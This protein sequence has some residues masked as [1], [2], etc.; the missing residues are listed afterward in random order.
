MHLL[1]H[2]RPE[3]FHQKRIGSYLTRVDG[4]WIKHP[5]D[6]ALPLFEIDTDFADAY[7]WRV[8]CF[9]PSN[10]RHI[11]LNEIER[12]VV[13]GELGPREVARYEGAN[14]DDHPD[15]WSRPLTEMPYG[16]PVLVWVGASYWEE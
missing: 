16:C 4:C 6:L 15:S 5:E 11:S 8:C 12:S 9:F 2:A 3:K 1:P 10:W 13:T 14:E 7:W